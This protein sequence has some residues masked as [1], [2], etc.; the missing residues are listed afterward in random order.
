[1]VACVA[2]SERQHVCSGITIYDVRE[3]QRE[4]E[5]KHENSH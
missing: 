4:R 1:M 2:G 3:R 5:E